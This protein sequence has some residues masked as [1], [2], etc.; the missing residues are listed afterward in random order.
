MRGDWSPSLWAGAGPKES[1]TRVRHIQTV[2][3]ATQGRPLEVDCGF[4][5]ASRLIITRLNR[6]WGCHSLGA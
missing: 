1:G 2:W 5:Y 6:I 4:T 3:N